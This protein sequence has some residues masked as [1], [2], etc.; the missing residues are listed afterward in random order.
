MTCVY[1]IVHELK[2]FWHGKFRMLLIFSV[3]KSLFFFSGLTIEGEIVVKE[4]NVKDFNY[5]KINDPNH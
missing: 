3:L 5:H 2:T 1:Y 4:Y